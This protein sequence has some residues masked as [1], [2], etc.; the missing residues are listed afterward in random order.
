MK[1][2]IHEGDI[3]ELST[4]YERS[5]SEIAMLTPMSELLDKSLTDERHSFLTEVEKK[6]GFFGK[7]DYL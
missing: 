5:L 4:I 7:S 1:S 6:T 2:Q 3:D